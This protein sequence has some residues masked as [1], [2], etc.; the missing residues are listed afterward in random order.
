MHYGTCSPELELARW[1]VAEGAQRVADQRRRIA[2]QVHADR[3]RLARCTIDGRSAAEGKDPEADQIE[4]RNER[5]QHTPTAAAGM[6]QD[7]GNGHTPTRTIANSG[8]TTGISHSHSG[9]T[10]LHGQ[11]C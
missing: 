2:E 4:Q 7:G 11:N 5:E 8:M 1:H 9:G 3:P 10:A 6:V